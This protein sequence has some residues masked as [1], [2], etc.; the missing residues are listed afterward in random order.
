MAFYFASVR[1]KLCPEVVPLSLTIPSANAIFSPEGK[2]FATLFA[3][4]PLQLEC[5]ATLGPITVAYETWGQLNASGDNA[6]LVCHALTGESHA[7][8]HDAAD[9]AGWWEAAVG[10][11]HPLDTRRFCV[12]SSNVLGGCQGTTGPGSLN[13]ATGRPFGMRFP[14]VTPRD[15]VRVQRALLD[16]LGVTRLLLVI[17]GSLGGMQS[18]QWAVTYPDFVRGCVPIGA[19]GRFHPQGIAWNEVQRQAIMLDPRWQGGDYYDSEPP[20]QGMGVARML[21][22]ITY[23]SDESM[24]AQFGRE[25]RGS[26]TDLSKGFGICYQTESYLHHHAETLSRRFDPNSYLYLSK[27][28]DLH[29]VGRGFADYASAF[30]RLRAK[31][32]AVG[33]R[34]DVLFPPQLSQEIV[35]LTREAGGH[36][37]YW[38]LDSKWGHDAFLVDFELMADVL[39]EFIRS[40]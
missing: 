21:G 36:A 25:V 38:E 9:R 35:D 8:H 16:Y 32:L 17:G 33:I 11:G 23:R 1:Q 14:L 26:G 3:A 40:L 18:V 24:W 20:N 7:A 15:M 2:Q 34:S 31:L 4:A 5:G 6:I 29:D 19:A 10:P 37:R 28:M 13:P 12:I 30:G 22:M 27:A 39:R